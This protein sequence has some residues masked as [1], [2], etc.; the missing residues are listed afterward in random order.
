M[1]IA[2]DEE[3]TKTGR[4][5]TL[6]RMMQL[7]P[8]ASQS[9]AFSSTILIP[10]VTDKWIQMVIGFFSSVLVSGSELCGWTALTLLA[11][12]LLCL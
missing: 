10:P 7:L 8:L 3:Q 1:Q 6:G 4:L 5:K 12:F 9:L 11:V 2:L